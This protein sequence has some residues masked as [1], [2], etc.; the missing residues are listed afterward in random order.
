VLGNKRAGVH[1]C[2]AMLHARVEAVD[3]A[4]QF[5]QDGVVEL[6]GATVRRNGRAAIVTYDHPRFLNAEDQGTLDAMEICVDLALLDDL[7]EIVGCAASSSTTQN[8][9]DESSV[10]ASI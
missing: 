8:T 10:P 4:A 6:A 7:S 1:L 9:A 5:R 3:L 2:H